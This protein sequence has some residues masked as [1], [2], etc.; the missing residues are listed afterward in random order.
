M[1]PP[2]QPSLHRAIATV[3][4]SSKL[5]TIDRDHLLI[6]T[7]CF[8]F[9]INVKVETCFAMSCSRRVSSIASL[10]WIPASLCRQGYLVWDQSPRSC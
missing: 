5:A 3:Q 7:L 10:A 9:E 6:F 4:G 2:F 1:D 8:N